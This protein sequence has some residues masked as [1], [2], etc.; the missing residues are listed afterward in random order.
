MASNIAYDHE[1]LEEAMELGHFKTKKE[2]LNTA[3][4]EFVLHRKQLE[5]LNLFG[6]VN[7]DP[8]YDHKKGRQKR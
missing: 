6:K 7:F 2:A 5:I 1:L 3:L 8:G 4:K